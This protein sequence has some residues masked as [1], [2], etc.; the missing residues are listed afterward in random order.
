MDAPFMRS[1]FTKC[2]VCPLDFFPLDLMTTSDQLCFP[3]VSNK[4]K[5]LITSQVIWSCKHAFFGMFPTSHFTLDVELK[6]AKST[7]SHF[8]LDVELKCAKSKAHVVK[9]GVQKNNFI[10][11]YLITYA[12]FKLLQSFKIGRIWKSNVKQLRKV[13]CAKKYLGLQ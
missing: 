6:C 5:F 7:T 10:S 9:D 8:T 12:L 3:Q 11:I 1:Q 2:I 13:T 4:S